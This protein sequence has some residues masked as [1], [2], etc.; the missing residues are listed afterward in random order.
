MAKITSC[1]LQKNESTHI[2]KKVSHFFYWSK[3]NYYIENNWLTHPLSIW[4][5]NCIREVVFQGRYIH[6]NWNCIISTT[7]QFHK[8]DLIEMLDVSTPNSF[9]GQE[10]IRSKNFFFVKRSL[11]LIRLNDTAV[12]K[13]LVPWLCNTIHMKVPS[14]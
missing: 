2:K 12:K 1:A 5:I 14:W 11:Y 7:N 4:H 6:V 3:I 9:T 10:W 8:F 13:S